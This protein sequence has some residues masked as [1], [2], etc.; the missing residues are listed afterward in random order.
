MSGDKIVVEFCKHALAVV[1]FIKRV[2]LETES[3]AVHFREHLIVTIL[4]ETVKHF[5]VAIIIL[6]IGP[7]TPRLVP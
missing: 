1:I 3:F 4:V 5:P 2:T 7:R 6:I